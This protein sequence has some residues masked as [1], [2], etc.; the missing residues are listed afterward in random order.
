MIHKNK[1]CDCTQAASSLL[2]H[3]NIY[4]VASELID[5]LKRKAK[6]NPRLRADYT[7][8]LAFLKALLPSLNAICNEEDQ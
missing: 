6:D 4:G 5:A 8:Q 3:L 7:K 2:D 1:C